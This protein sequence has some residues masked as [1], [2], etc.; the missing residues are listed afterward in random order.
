M[1]YLFFCQEV[2][3]ENI[4]Y[5]GLERSYI[6]YVPTS[7]SPNSETPLVLNL[8]GYGSNAG[9]QMIYSN[10]YP[11]SDTEGFIL[12]HPEGTT[13]PNGFQFWNSGGMSQVDDVGFLNALIDQISLDFPSCILSNKNNRFSHFC[14]SLYVF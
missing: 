14:F 4:V 13:G 12:V 2:T 10:F 5:D 11:I 8:H 1:P 6:L 9:Q 3:E 7:Y